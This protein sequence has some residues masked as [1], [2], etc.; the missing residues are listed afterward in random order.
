[1]G[2]RTLSATP[3]VRERTAA[4]G[5]S[6]DHDSTQAG[7]G[8]RLLEALRA[9]DDL[10]VLEVCGPTTRVSAENMTW[11][12]LGRDQIQLMLIEARDRFPGLTY[13]SRTRQVG[14]G[15]VIEEARV[16]DV[17]PEPVEVASGD[18]DGLPDPDHPMYDDP[19]F[20][21]VS[22][23]RELTLWRDLG[24][25]EPAA[26][27]NM[28]VRVTVRHDA[29]QVHD[30][31][32]SFPAAL[33]KRAL[34]ERVDPFELSLSEV[35]SAFVAPAEAE[36]TIRALGAQG[37]GPTPGAADGRRRE[38]EV[39]EGRRPRRWRRWLPLLLGTMALVAAGALALTT[40]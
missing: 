39:G 16:R 31:S 12:C 34:G 1:M 24:G 28:P 21:P 15:L 25:D 23:S 18:L 36:L 20:A 22:T 38:D 17:Q 14:A 30:V 37:S 33:L 32:F 4:G 27:L 19:M 9:G 11:S 5:A 2:E 3:E 8:L 26:P 10:G 6:Y 40:H 7:P 29:L 13:E 35:Q